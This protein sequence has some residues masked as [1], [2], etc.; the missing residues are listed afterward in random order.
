MY[1]YNG[2]ERSN[3]KAMA[4]SRPHSPV[5][6]MVDPKHLQNVEYFK[7]LGSMTTNDA[8]CTCKIKSRTVMAK[9]ALNKKKTLLTSK[10]DFNLREKLAKRY[11]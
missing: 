3:S 11:V 10:M 2:Y 5:R 4:I 6:I 7:Y 8:R 1:E 9:E